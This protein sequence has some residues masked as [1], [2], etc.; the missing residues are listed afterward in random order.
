MKTVLLALG[1]FISVTACSSS[2]DDEGNTPVLS[3]KEKAVAVLNSIETGDQTAVAYINPENYKQHNLGIAD[4]LAGFGKALQQ[5]PKGSAKVNVIRAF[6]DGEYVFFHT[7]YNFF[8]PKAGFDIFRFEEGKI[9]EHWDNLAA[10]T[11]PN[12]S[13]RTQF[14]GS[15]Q[16]SN[17]DQT[18]ANKKLVEDFVNT[19]L[20]KGQMDQLG[21]YFDGDKYL[22]HNSTIADGLSGLGKAMEELGKMGI[23]M[24]YD[25]VHM[26]LGE[27]N[28]VLVVSE[29]KFGDKHTSYYDLF[30]VENGKIAEHW[31]VIESIL[32]ES[33]WKNYNGK[34]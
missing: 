16:S 29:G 28:F 4:G 18:E 17:I 1:L 27:G 11:A 26:V 21:N 25:K 8:G 20:V 30:R 24:V 7:Q 12:P 13:G 2:D 9:V 33:E 23:A 10:I 34:Y 3:N 32:P 14:D 31:D 5:L 22:Q 6:E 19:I 15:T